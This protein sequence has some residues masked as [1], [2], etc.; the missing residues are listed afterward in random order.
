VQAQAV[1]L[2][3]EN[4]MKVQAYGDWS[5]GVHQR[6]STKRIPIGGSIEITQRCNNQCIH[7]YNNLSVGD[8]KARAAEL[9]LDEYC[10]ILDEIVDAGCLWLLFTGGEIFIRQDFLDIYTYARQKG[11]LITLFTNGTLISP[12]IVEQLAQFPPFSIEITIYGHT[13]ETYESITK[14]SGSFERC[15]NGIHL[16]MDHKLPLKL[17]TMAITTNKHEIQEMR[18]FVEENL[19]LEFKFDA[20]INPRLDC[21]QSPLDV[22]LT[23]AEVVELDLRYSERAGEWKH[24]AERFIKPEN[25]TEYPSNLYVCGAGNNSFAIDPYGRLR[26]CVLSSTDSY[27]LRKG[28][29]MEGWDKHLAGARRKKASRHTKCTGCRLKSMCGM[30]PANSELECA[31]AEAPVD[32]LCRVAHL[33]AYA[34]GLPV[35][36]HGRCEY[37]EGGS[38]YAEMMET[39]KVLKERSAKQ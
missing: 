2:K 1:N 16:L 19:G 6:L 31:D 11:L 34:F 32:F 9:A 30:C 27:D 21:S 7:C 17:K 24:F 36:S 29:F 4:K 38:R 28:S 35:A 14:I 3:S 5:L 23:P 39:A 37:C 20:M 26:L 8:R 13:K 10:R 25:E 33:R 22:R 12:A 18:Q 15:L